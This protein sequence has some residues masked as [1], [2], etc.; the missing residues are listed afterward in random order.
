MWDLAFKGTPGLKSHFDHHCKK[1]IVVATLETFMCPGDLT[2]SYV[3]LA[4]ALPSTTPPAHWL[5]SVTPRKHSPWQFT[6][7]MGY[8]EAVL[9]PTPAQPPFG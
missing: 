6:L 9:G 2:K 1:W 4:T 3:H 5:L 7:Q 8:L